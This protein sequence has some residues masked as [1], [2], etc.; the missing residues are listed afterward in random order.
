MK[1]TLES[2]TRVVEIELEQGALVPG[3]IWEGVTDSGIR[4]VALITRIAAET[5]VGEH[6]QAEFRQELEECHEPRSRGALEA[7]PS[8]MVI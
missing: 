6:T 7:F 2:T 8:R 1:V 5:G 3:R 4:V